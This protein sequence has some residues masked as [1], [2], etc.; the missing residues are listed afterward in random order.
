M[1]PRL[2][3]STTLRP[4]SS[5]ARASGSDQ[6]AAQ[7]VHLAC[8][9]PPGA[10]R[11]APRPTDGRFDHRLQVLHI[12]GRAVVQDHQIEGELPHP[13]VFM[14]GQHFHQAGASSASSIRNSRIGRSPEI[15]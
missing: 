9:L 4:T 1:L 14:R 8:G 6:I 2:A 12:R 5:S 3:T 7:D 11:G 15:P 13:Q 10:A